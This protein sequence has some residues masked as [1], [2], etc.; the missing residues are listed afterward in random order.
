MKKWMDL[1]LRKRILIVCFTAL[2]AVGIIFACSSLLHSVQDF[3]NLVK[4]IA[5]YMISVL[6]CIYLVL[7]GIMLCL[8]IKNKDQAMGVR[9]FGFFVAGCCLIG[10]GSIVIRTGVTMW[11]E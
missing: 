5:T 6:G 10:Y 1:T 9:A 7:S 8:S 2:L 3:H 11:W 4:N